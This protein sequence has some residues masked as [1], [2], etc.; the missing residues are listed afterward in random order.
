MGGAG[1]GAAATRGGA[2]ARPKMEKLTAEASLEARR[3]RRKK[4]GGRHRRHQ[5]IR[6]ASL[7]PVL[8]PVPALRFSHLCPGGDIL[9]VATS[10]LVAISWML[11][12]AQLFGTIVCIRTKNH[13]IFI[14]P[15]VSSFCIMIEGKILPAGFS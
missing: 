8:A 14:L 15:T 3:Q 10:G 13:V 4:E 11:N 6:A 5:R 9:D 1:R 2:P 7:V 12:C